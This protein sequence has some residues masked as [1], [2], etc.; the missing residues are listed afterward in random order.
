MKPNPTLLLLSVVSLHAQ[1]PAPPVVI[2]RV[3][4]P[5]VIE[6]KV[7]PA[8]PPVVV[9]RTVTEVVPPFDPALVRQRLAIVPKAVP[10]VPP[11]ATVETTETVVRDPTNRIYHVERNVVIVDGQELPYVTL[12]VL[13]EIETAKLR[14]STSR[15][16][17][18]H[19]AQAILE[20]LATNPEA[21]FKIEGHT[22][23]DGE[24]D[25]NLKL[26]GDRARRVYDELTAR[27]GVPA[28]ALGAEGFGE[29]YPSHP[30]G[31]A[32]ELELDRRVLVVRVK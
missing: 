32:A 31:T 2:E 29:K 19:T 27:Y 22:S 14:D 9:E 23:V 4:P 17:L 30:N 18:E 16:A 20:V 13:F 12:P 8:P 11:G 6:E 28:K 24:E 3:P 5:V 15:A 1:E 10:V 25:F 21:G 26:S 7:V